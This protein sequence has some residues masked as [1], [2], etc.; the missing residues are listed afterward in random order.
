MMMRVIAC[1][2]L[3]AAL[4]CGG[5]SPPRHPDTGAG[6]GQTPPTTVNCVD[7]CQRSSQCLVTLCDEDTMST[8]YDALLDLVVMQCQS[9]CVDAT[10]QSMI[11][12]TA[13]QC[14]FQSSCR[15]VF[16]YNTC[17]ATPASYRCM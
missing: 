11:N 10:I 4:G 6:A 1:A 3:A 2:I 17:N 8:Q 7:F 12:P 13:W 9:S 14:L 15:Q 16:E 5:D